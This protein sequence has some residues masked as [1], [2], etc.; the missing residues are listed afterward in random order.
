MMIMICQS[1]NVRVVNQWFEKS[2]TQRIALSMCLL[3]CSMP[4]VTC[5]LCSILYH[6]I[7]SKNSY[8]TKHLF[9]YMQG[10]K[11]LIGEDLLNKYAEE[12]VN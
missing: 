4:E 7:S 1:C 6:A 5:H 9:F 10:C 8:A 2:A 3:R 12:M 11:L